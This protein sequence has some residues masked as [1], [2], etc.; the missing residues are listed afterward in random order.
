[1]S[2]KVVICWRMALLSQI[3]CKKAPHFY[4]L[5]VYASSTSLWLRLGGSETQSAE[6]CFRGGFCF[7]FFLGGGCLCAVFFIQFCASH[8]DSILELFEQL[9]KMPGPSPQRS[10]W[11]VWMR[12]GYWD[13]KSS[14]VILMYGQGCT[15]NLSSFPSTFSTC[16]I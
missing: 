7:G 2:P 3:C 16:L 5:E 1:M 10:D 6:R 11:K 4:F 15:L 12:P 9:Y 8:F 13:F 14:Q